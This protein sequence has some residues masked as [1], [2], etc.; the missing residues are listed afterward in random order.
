MDSIRC[1][2]KKAGD[3]FHISYDTFKTLQIRDFFISCTMERLD[4]GHLHPKLEVPRLTFL[5][6]ESK[7]AST[8]SN[9]ELF[10]QHNHSYSEDQHMIPWQYA[11]QFGPCRED[12]CCN[13][14]FRPMRSPYSSSFPRYASPMLNAS[15]RG[16]QL[17]GPE[18][19]RTTLS[20]LLRPI[21]YYIEIIRCIFVWC[22]TSE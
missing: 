21:L 22:G 17:I 3:S 1:K 15:A 9:K 6:R 4:Q 5:D 14:R 11:Y 13:S 7:R 12:C 19:E 20:I 8:H 2:Q 16:I 18:T 10:E